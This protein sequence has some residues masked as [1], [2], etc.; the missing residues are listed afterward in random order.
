MVLKYIQ[1]HK[2]M[3]ECFFPVMFDY[4][5]APNIGVQ[6]WTPEGWFKNDLQGWIFELQIV[7]KH[8]GDS[9]YIR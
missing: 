7:P 8:F 6:N 5:E 4:Q 3:I 2:T 9:G 1:T